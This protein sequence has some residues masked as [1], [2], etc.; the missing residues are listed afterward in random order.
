[1]ALGSGSSE[2]LTGIAESWTGYQSNMLPLLIFDEP[3]KPQSRHLYQSM[4]MSNSLVSHRPDP[5]DQKLSG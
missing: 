2:V 4:S 5:V 1:M 3:Q